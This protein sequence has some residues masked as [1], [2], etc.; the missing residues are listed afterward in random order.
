MVVWCGVVWWWCGVGG[1]GV[2]GGLVVV[3]VVVV[4]GWLAGWLNLSRCDEEG[5]RDIGFLGKRSV[6]YD[7]L[8]KYF[9]PLPRSPRRPP[10]PP[11]LSPV[12]GRAYVPPRG[13][14]GFQ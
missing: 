11:P 6:A 14:T 5:V 9:Q 4:A 3:V 12:A 2:M 7:G 8:G 13:Y 1:V 10:P